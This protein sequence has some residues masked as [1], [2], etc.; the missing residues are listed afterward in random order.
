MCASKTGWDAGEILDS[1][2]D[3]IRSF[4]E[5][6][7]LQPNFIF[8]TGDA[9]FGHLGNDGG[10]SISEQFREAFTLFEEIRNTFNPGIPKEN[11]FIVPGNHDVNRREI[12]D[13]ITEWLETL[14]RNDNGGGLKRI[15]KMIAS[16]DNNW[17]IVTQRLVDY[18]KA[19]Q[20]FGYTHL[21]E[22]ADRLVYSTTR[23]INGVQVGIAG[24]NSAWSS[25][26][27]SEKGKLW[28][29][30]HWQIQTLRSKIK[31]A[32]VKIALT[33]HPLNWFN[34]FEDPELVPEFERNF[35]ILLHGHEHQNW[36]TRNGH[37]ARIAA[38]ACY[39]SSEKET[40]YSFGEL[41]F[42]NGILR[43][44]LRKYDT[45]GGKW[46]PRIIGNQTDNNGRWTIENF[47]IINEPG[48]LKIATSP[49]NEE[50][51]K[52]IKGPE[53]RGIFGR[54]EDIRKISKSMTSKGIA[55]VYGMSGIGKTELIKE[56]CKQDGF[57]DYTYTRMRAYSK[58]SL[59]DFY[60][61]ISPSLGMHQEFP[62]INQIN[63]RPD[64]SFLR[65]TNLSPTIIHIDMAHELHK[66]RDIDS[67]N[68]KNLI[69]EI[70]SNTSKV[71]FI[72]ESREI[73]PEG[74]FNDDICS[75][76]RVKGLD[77]ESVIAYFNNPFRDDV[78]IGWKLSAEEADF[79][80]KYLGGQRSNDLAHPLA[81]A[82]LAIVSSGKKTDPASA[83]RQH[84]KS[85]L[86][87]L[88]KFLFKDLYKNILSPTQAHMLRLCALYREGIPDSHIE[89]LCKI[90][91]DGRSFEFLVRRCLLTTND[92]E[93]W[94]Y[95]H[96]I[97]NS[98]THDQM[99]DEEDEYLDNN[100]SIA[101]LWLANLGKSKRISLPNIR[102]SSEAIYHFLEAK[103]FE[104]LSEFT[105]NLAWHSLIPDLE[106]V[107]HNLYLNEKYREQRY[108]LELL[109]SLE[110]DNTK[111][112]RYLGDSIERIDGIGNSVALEHYWKAYNLAPYFSNNLGCIAR[113]LIARREYEKYVEIVL[114]FD[115]Q[116]FEK[117]MDPKYN[118]SMYSRCLSKLEDKVKASNIR[119]KLIDKE[120][121]NPG[122]Y[123]DEASYLAQK[124]KKK[125]ALAILA[126]AMKLKIANEQTHKLHQQYSSQLG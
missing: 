38:G 11:F 52:F 105:E 58:A 3:D 79:V 82:L 50:V 112:H 33:H 122:F 22:D 10:L 80:Y 104:R 126:L 109:V 43:I 94:Y 9:A 116:E 28:L 93:E 36:I 20:D 103:E 8:F 90:S 34:E 121:K 88:E 49:R 76:F 31:D 69:E 108:V 2:R 13:S 120:V 48:D 37:H 60:Q 73:A 78:E 68:I 64:M 63:G 107:S 45:L 23:D 18:K 91:E 62:E 83:L 95:L 57:K 4:T 118:L 24:L 27:D 81:M 97:I 117:V 98:L 84:E 102:S 56:V 41:D 53:A 66:R 55:F 32:H 1:L 21:L 5:T 19:L 96:D 77:K 25:A 74:L 67:N 92:K 123:N 59:L 99:D 101:D 29:A 14:L 125:E 47:L 113:S 71:K 54:D 86:D 12:A 65:D 30:G 15:S 16:A 119:Q 87:D 46:I 89:S 72:L 61:Q 124:G 85:L 111:F 110:P 40:G 26:K 39:G 7:K 75:Y 114:N 42:E 70:I 6:H 17:R 115:D 106:A 51:T 100:R 35:N 44:W